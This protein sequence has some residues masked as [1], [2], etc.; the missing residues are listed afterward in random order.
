MRCRQSKGTKAGDDQ[1]G[2]GRDERVCNCGSRTPDEPSRERQYRDR[3][4]PGHEPVCDRI[5]E[6]LD[7]GLNA[8]RSR[9]ESD[10]LGEQCVLTNLLA[11]SRRASDTRPLDTFHSTR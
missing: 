3:N 7:R 4:D 11:G 1:Y 10:N 5:R 6:P 2:D 9:H 8:L